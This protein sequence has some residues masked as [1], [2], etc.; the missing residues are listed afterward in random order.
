MS[1][2]TRQQRYSLLAV[3]VG[4]LVLLPAQATHATTITVLNMD[5]AGEGFNDPAARAPVGGNPGVTLGQQRLN[6]FQEAADRWAAVVDSSVVIRTQGNFDPLYCDPF[7]AVLGS[8][9]PQTVHANFAGAPAANTWYAQATANSIA[10]SDLD[11]TYDDIGATFNSDIDNGCLSGVSG[12][13]YGFD[14]NPGAG[15][16]D[17]IP[18]LLHELAHGLG[19]LSLVN[20]A[21]GAKFY[22]WNDTY[23][24]NL[25]NHSTGVL[26][27]AMSDAQRV[28]ASINTGNLHWVGANV[29]AASTLLSA[30]KTGDHVHM[31][32]PN[33]NKPGSS[34]SHFD[35][36]LTPDELM[37]PIATA[38]NIQDLTEA[39]LRDIGWTLLPSG[40]TPTPTVTPT[41]TAPTPTVTA[42]PALVLPNKCL[43]GKTKCVNKKLAGMLKCRG[44]CQK[45]PAKCG[46]VQT[47]CEAKVIAKFDGGTK[48]IASGCIGKLDVKNDGPCIT[49]GDT[50]SLEAKIDAYVTD[51]LSELEPTPPSG[52]NKCLAGKTK[53]VSKKTEG[54]LKCRGKCQKDPFKCGGVQTACEAKVIAKF[55]GGTKGIASGCIGKLDVKNDGPCETFG[56]T[57][58]LEAKADA[59]V[60]DVLTELETTP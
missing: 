5:G 21:S 13:Y 44:K 47:V 20:L 42:T 54:L 55:D 16:I 51:V 37:E 52:V 56:D 19:F 31:Y 18:T 60:T 10:G 23:M 33:P 4:L 8:A 34:V 25:E 35:T 49:L 9:G 14:G 43:A 39:L 15:Q 46:G 2:R 57:A 24:L 58:P 28:A 11:V 12:W 59:F 17:F 30:G 7:S 36:S 40:P 45:D 27:P 29:R 32:A 48:G 53:C 50:A 38:T 1:S 22:G 6:A 3:T 26:Y 41:S